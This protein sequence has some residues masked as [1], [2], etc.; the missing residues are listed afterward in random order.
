MDLNICM[1]WT[2][3]FTMFFYPGSLLY[4]DIKHFIIAFCWDFTVCCI[5]AAFILQ[6]LL[7][8][9]VEQTP[10]QQGIPTW[11]IMHLVWVNNER[12]AVFKKRH[13]P[14][15]CTFYKLQCWRSVRVSVPQDK[16]V[17]CVGG[18]EGWEQGSG[19]DTHPLNSNPSWRHSWQRAINRKPAALVQTH[20]HSSAQFYFKLNT[21][22]GD[23]WHP[24]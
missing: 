13:L 21:Y 6:L 2:N 18:H 17:F 10:F 5:T 19:N 20:T 16:C 1:W 4:F 24:W 8:C 7:C 12:A 22:F 23:D 3:D 15:T 14:W 9:F 11:D